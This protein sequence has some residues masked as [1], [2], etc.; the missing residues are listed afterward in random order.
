MVTCPEEGEDQEIV[1]LLRADLRSF[2]SSKS[3]LKHHQL[4]S[5]TARQHEASNMQLPTLCVLLMSYLCLGCF[6]SK[7]LDIQKL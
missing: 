3:P 4:A 2:G 6:K 5:I 7:S 1:E